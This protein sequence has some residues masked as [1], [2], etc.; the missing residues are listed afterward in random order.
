MA[1]SRSRDVGRVAGQ[2]RW[3]ADKSGAR[4]WEAVKSEETGSPAAAAREAAHRGARGTTLVADCSQR[5]VVQLVRP[6]SRTRRELR[7]PGNATCPGDTTD[8]CMAP[9]TGYDEAAAEE[10][11]AV[12]TQGIGAALDIAALAYSTGELNPGAATSKEVGTGASED[13]L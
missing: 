1:L 10:V 12:G 9:E 6:R 13:P 2:A 7:W 11:Y 8:P 5:C 4:S 3:V